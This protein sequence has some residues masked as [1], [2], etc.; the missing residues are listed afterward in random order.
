MPSKILVEI[1]WT[2]GII[3]LW[4]PVED[5]GRD[6]QKPLAKILKWEHRIT[7]LYL[8]HVDKLRYE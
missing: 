3:F 5:N 4:K 1:K 6:R 7:E 2:C 8:L